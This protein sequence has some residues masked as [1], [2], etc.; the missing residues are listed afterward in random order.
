MSCYICKE[1]VE[2]RRIDLYVIGSE[3]IDVCHDCE[4]ILVDT[5]RNFSLI[6]TK[7]KISVHRK[8]KKRE[9]GP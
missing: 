7:A 9:E 2:V 3:G 5:A 4:L 6:A 1:D 8:L